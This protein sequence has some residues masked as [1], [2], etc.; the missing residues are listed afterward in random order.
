MH[1]LDFPFPVFVVS[2]GSLWMATLGGVYFRKRF[3]SIDKEEREDFSIV[4]TAT[5]TLLGLIIGFT[6]SM[7]VSRYDLRKH[8]EEEEANSI[9][10]EYLRAD[11][12]PAAD[13]PKIRG[14]LME[15]LQLRLVFYTLSGYAHGSARRLDEIGVRTTQLQ[16][17]MWSMLQ[18]SSAAQGTATIALAAAGMNDVVNSQGYAQ[19]AWRNRVPRAAWILM[20]TIAIFCNLLMGF[21]AVHVRPV[22]LPVLP[23]ILSVAFFLIADIDSP[24]NG[25]IRVHP[26]NLLSLSASLNAH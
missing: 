5:L 14:L 12:L 24:R 7:A 6:F 21:G 2:F 25:V 10:T 1:L 20:G 13:T 4:L 22:L 15:Y 8:Y 16:Y 3:R 19:G 26:E 23:I 11:L 9:G 17:K 18:S